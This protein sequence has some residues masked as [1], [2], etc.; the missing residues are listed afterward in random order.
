MTNGS[1]AR[2][3]C[4]AIAVASLAVSGCGEAPADAR[5]GI[6]APNGSEKA[7]GP[8]GSY[9]NHRCGTLDCHGKIERNFRVWGCEGMRLLDTDVSICSRAKGG[10]ATTPEEHQATYRS[11]VG[12]EPTVMSAVVEDHGKDPE[13][14]TFIRKARGT[15]SHKGG[16]LVVPGDDQDVCLT[17][18]LAGQT[19]LT[20]CNAAF[21]Q[22]KF[23][24]VP[25]Q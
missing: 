3:L 10:R 25:A 11:L 19:N 12:L 20:A 14:L 21:A 15:E 4:A 24:P 1:L 17:S 6:I 16:A 18:W 9:L 22:P 13:L 2:L 8:V 5:I 7:F 23:P